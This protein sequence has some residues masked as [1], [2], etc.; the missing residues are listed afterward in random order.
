MRGSSARESERE[1]KQKNSL[2]PPSF[3]RLSI[4]SLL[5]QLKNTTTTTNNNN[6][7]HSWTKYEEKEKE[8]EEKGILKPLHLFTKD[9]P[10]PGKLNP[11][12]ALIAP[13]TR[14]YIEGFKWVRSR[15][16]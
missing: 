10:P 4:L 1:D 7:L 2:F 9:A 12:K 11:M 6:I 13:T 16:F 15:G 3:F 5:L 8:R 14:K